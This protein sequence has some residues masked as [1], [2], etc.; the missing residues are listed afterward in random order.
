MELLCN[1]AYLASISGKAWGFCE[2][3]GALRALLGL[4]FAMQVLTIIAVGI[5]LKESADHE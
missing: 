3:S 1:L 5:E 2:T 4:A